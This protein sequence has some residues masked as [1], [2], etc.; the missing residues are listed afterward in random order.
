MHEA[1]ACG[2]IST[3]SSVSIDNSLC[4]L[5]FCVV[6]LVGLHKQRQCPA[7]L[8]RPP[9]CWQRGRTAQLFPTLLANT[10]VQCRHLTAL[11]SRKSVVRASTSTCSTKEPCSAKLQTARIEMDVMNITKEGQASAAHNRL[12]L[13]WVWWI[14][15]R[16]AK[17]L[18]SMTDFSILKAASLQPTTDIFVMK[19]SY[20][21]SI[22]DIFMSF[23]KERKK[24]VGSDPTIS[25][26]LSRADSQKVTPESVELP[27]VTIF[28]TDTNWYDLLHWKTRRKKTRQK[29]RL[30]PCGYSCNKK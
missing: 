19:I 7:R 9:R 12:S 21:Q 20:F 1:P 2:S 15:Q 22:K 27:T 4:Y 11:L 17:C 5:P 26:L 14:L 3:V 6:S 30:R 28:V 18:R 24:D 10:D 23:E 25:T 13:R 8:R 16:K 29:I